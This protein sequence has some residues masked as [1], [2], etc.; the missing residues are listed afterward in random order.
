MKLALDYVWDCTP[1]SFWE[2]YFDPQFVVRLHLEGLGST[3]AEV[4]SQEG[5]L[6]SGLVRTLRYSQRP[7]APAPVRRIF[8]EEIVTT[9]V[10]TFDPPSSTTTFTI[11]P[12]T[13]A[14][15]TRIHGTIALGSDGGHTTEDFSLEAQVKIFGVGPIVE[16]FIE[17]QAREIQERSVAFMR[18][19]LDPSS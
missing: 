1:E 12:G 13:M 8:G 14:D 16:K 9:E 11:T 3:T 19:L 4:V 6:T 15:K 18:P 5:D 7:N 10:S 17:H 2:L